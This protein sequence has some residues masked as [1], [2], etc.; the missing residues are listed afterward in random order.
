MHPCDSVI[1]AWPLTLSTVLLAD[2]PTQFFHHV[3][4]V[5]DVSFQRIFSK[6]FKITSMVILTPLLLMSL[7]S[8]APFKGQAESEGFFIG[9][10]IINFWERDYHSYKTQC[11]FVK[12][13]FQATSREWKEEIQ[14]DQCELWAGEGRLSLCTWLSCTWFLFTWVINISLWKGD[15]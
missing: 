3:R 14:W 13:T 12:G 2:N 9:G 6:Y 5:W 10:K 7:L 8:K 4:L 11:Q 15:K 1:C